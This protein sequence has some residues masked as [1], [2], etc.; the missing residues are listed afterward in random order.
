MIKNGKRLVKG[1]KMRKK[2]KIKILERQT[3]E[4]N[5]AMVEYES[6]H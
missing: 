6:T 2:K 5:E 1:G 3:T 4:T